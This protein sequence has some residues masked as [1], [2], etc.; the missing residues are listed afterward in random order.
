MREKTKRKKRKKTDKSW[1][2]EK[3]LKWKRKKRKEKTK[4]KKH[5]PLICAL[6]E[7]VLLVE[8]GKDKNEIKSVWKK[9]EKKKRKG[10]SK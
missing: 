10:G 2:N 6:L 4:E 8:D 3:C 7:S 9:K 5:C 1:I